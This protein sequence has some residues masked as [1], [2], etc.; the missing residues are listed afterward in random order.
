MEE[1]PSEKREERKGEEFLTF[2]V[3]VPER[4]C[5]TPV[6]RKYLCAVIYISQVIY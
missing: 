1:C 4:D 2:L 6:E 3:T 5:G